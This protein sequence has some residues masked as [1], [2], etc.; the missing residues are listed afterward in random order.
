MSQWPTGQSGGP[1]VS[2]FSYRDRCLYDNVFTE[3]WSVTADSGASPS[4]RA[5]GFSDC[6]PPLMDNQHLEKKKHTKQNIKYNIHVHGNM[7]KK[8]TLNE[9]NFILAARS[10]LSQSTLQHFLRLQSQALSWS[11]IFSSCSDAAFQVSNRAQII[12]G[13]HSHSSSILQPSSMTGSSYC[14]KTFIS[15]VA[16]LANTVTIWKWTSTWKMQN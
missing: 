10:Y 9:T 3:S 8:K 14:I 13:R 12:S 1:L 2:T 5:L 6:S 15:R 4:L 7:P 11:V 16:A